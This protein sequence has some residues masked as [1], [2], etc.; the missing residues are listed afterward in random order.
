LLCFVEFGRHSEELPRTWYGKSQRFWTFLY[1]G[2][3]ILL[4]TS[5]RLIAR[6]WRPRLESQTT[7]NQ[8]EFLTP[9]LR[10]PVRFLLTFSRF[11]ACCHSESILNE[12]KST[13]V[14]TRAH[15]N[16]RDYFGNQSY[17]FIVCYFLKPT[18]Q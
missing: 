2:Y 6:P 9:V 13:K 3:F 7:Q 15:T 17:C 14:A 10:V 8:Q 11:L 4:S 1:K 16:A 18:G 5:K 12:N